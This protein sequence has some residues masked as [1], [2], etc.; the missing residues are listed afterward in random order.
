LEAA[1]FAMVDPKPLLNKDKGNGNYFYF[2]HPLSTHGVL[3]EIVSAYSMDEN[4][5]TRFDWNDCQVFMVSP[6]LNQF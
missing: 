2:V 6:D 5:Q 3:L 4:Y 1:G